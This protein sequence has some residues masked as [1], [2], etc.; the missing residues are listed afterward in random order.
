MFYA[1][2]R[3]V[4]RRSYPGLKL[5]QKKERAPYLRPPTLQRG[6]RGAAPAEGPV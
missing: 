2:I 5:G 3:P 4:V 6:N 1:E